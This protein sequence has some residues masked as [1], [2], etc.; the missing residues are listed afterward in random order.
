MERYRIK[1]T[2]QAREQLR[3]IKRYISLNLNS[4]LSAE[5]TIKLLKGEMLNLS[6]MPHKIKCIDEK[7][8]GELGF[9]KIRVK[10]YYIYFLINH[11]K[12]EVQ[13]TSVIYVKRNQAKELKKLN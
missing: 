9:R 8:W 11:E 7:P 13:I 1:I 6:F 3:L 12:S 5:K 2:N 4:P 10:N